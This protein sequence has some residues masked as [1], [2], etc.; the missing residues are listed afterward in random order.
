MA[1][2]G[3]NNTSNITNLEP[4]HIP[5]NIVR[6]ACTIITIIISLII[7]GLIASKRTPRTVPMMLVANTCS[8]E[9]ICVC[10][11]LSLVSFTLNN[12]L[13]QIQYQDSLCIFRAYINYS[14]TVIQNH[15]YNLQAMYR[16]IT[17]VYPSRISWQSR[18]LNFCLIIITWI[19]GL[20]SFLPFLFTNFITYNIENQICQSPIQLSFP[21]IYI[22]L[23]IYIIPNMILNIIYMKLVRYVHAMNKRV[24]PAN[25]KSRAE[26]ELKMVRNIVIISTILVILGLPYAIFILMS[27]FTVIPKHHFRIAYISIDVSTT[28]VIIALFITTDPIKATAKQIINELE[29]LITRASV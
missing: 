23:I 28:A 1:T 18:R 6:M 2:F 16:Y 12:D 26:R 5:M 4:W 19:F 21:I 29:T 8:S 13:K 10:T 7:L 25:I 22:A 9:F 24:T 3:Y 20:V 15:S 27:F 14:M 11:A 17:V